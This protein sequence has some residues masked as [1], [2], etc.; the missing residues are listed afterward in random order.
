MNRMFSFMS[1]VFTIL[2]T[3][4]L[5][6][7]DLNQTVWISYSIQFSIFWE[8]RSKTVNWILANEVIVSVFL[9][10]ITLSTSVFFLYCLHTKSYVGL[11]VYSVWVVVYELLSFSL[12]LLAEGIIKTQFKELIHL[13]FTFQILRM[14]LHFLALPFIL[15]YMLSLYEDAK[16]QVRVARYCHSSGSMARGKSMLR[17]GPL[18]QHRLP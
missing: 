15:R 17:T 13:K 9:S 10:S 11:A 2:N 5:F 16:T 8:V 1:G 14:L 18:Y 6:I 12:G 4:Q 3:I 7:F